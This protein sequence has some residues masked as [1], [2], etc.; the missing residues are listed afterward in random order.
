VYLCVRQLEKVEPDEQDAIN[1]GSVEVMRKEL[2]NWG[3][4]DWVTQKAPNHA[5]REKRARG[6]GPAT[7]LPPASNAT[8]IF[9]RTVKKLSDFVE[10]LPS[11]KEHRQGRRFVV[12]YAKPFLE[13]SEPG[14]EYGYIEAPP[15]AKPDEHGVVSFTLDQA[16]RRVAGGASRYPDDALTAAIAA[17]LLTGTTT[18][19]LLDA[20]QWEPTQEVR[21]RARVL[22][23]GN[24]A[25]TRRDSLKNRAG[26]MAALIRGYPGGKGK[27]DNAASKEW[28]SAAWVVQERLAYKYSDNE[29]ARW[30]NEKDAFLAE[31]KKSGKVTVEDVRRLRSLDFKPY[32]GF[33]PP[34]LDPHPDFKHH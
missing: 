16:Y 14:E 11:R 33:P 17:A 23:E 18:D 22:W 8:S 4:P 2:A 6:S 30:L 15:D 32:P 19:E 12:S 7:D 21:E 27:H 1:A 24:T 29:I 3:A 10:R 9:Q 28:Q 34:G 26:Q 25:S 13:P 5:P 31:R 20:L